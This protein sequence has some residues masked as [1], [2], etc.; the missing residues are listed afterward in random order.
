[1][2]RHA[3]SR[4][5]IPA[6]RLADDARALR[7]DA[8]RRYSEL[9]LLAAALQDHIDDLRKE[10]DRLLSEVARLRDDARRERAGWLH[11]GMKANR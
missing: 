1:M 2:K 10:R 4:Q 6:G 8:E 9:H 11:R 5:L 7:S 3:G